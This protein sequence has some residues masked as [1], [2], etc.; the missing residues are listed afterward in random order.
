[1]NPNWYYAKDNRQIGPVSSD[2]LLR[3]LRTGELSPDH[4]VWRE[5]M[6][7]WQPIRD[8]YDL[9]P[10]SEPPAAQGVEPG[11]PAASAPPVQ[12]YYAVSGHRFGPTTAAAIQEMLRQGRLGGRDLVWRAGMP[13]WKSA[14]QVAEF[15]HLSPAMPPQFA[16]VSSDN[17]YAAPQSDLA[18]DF[19]PNQ[20][21]RFAGYAGFWA[22]FAAFIVDRI[23]VLA[24][25]FA[26]GFVFAF[27]LVIAN[28][29]DPAI[30][31]G[32]TGYLLNLAGFIGEWLYFALMESSRRQAT[33]GKMALGIVVTD[34]YGRRITFGRATGRYFAK[35]ISALILFLGFLMVAWTQR[36]Q[37]LH[38]MIAGTLV[39]RRY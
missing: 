22:R 33:V 28:E 15:A 6:T 29:G 17:P 30:L 35:I 31:E 39:Y 14:N 10:H 25:S 8:A 9:A 4:L 26:V 3:L 21:P 1:L 23:V 2:D 20:S 12:W 5:G 36:K 32:P 37:G 19:D 11:V 38:D 34:L 24:V 27:V 13:D 18:A 16:P 7:D